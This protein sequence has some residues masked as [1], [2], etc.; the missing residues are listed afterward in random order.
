MLILFL[1]SLAVIAYTYI[2]Y[3]LILAAVSS[4]ISIRVAKK[5]IYP[6]V[7]IIVSA[8]NEG[9]NIAARISNLLS[10]DYPRE[11]MEIIIGSDGSSDETYEIIKKFAEEHGIRYTVSFNRIGKPAMINKMAKDA[12]GEI[13]VFADAR[14]TFE[15]DALKKMVS[16]FADEDI[17]AVSGELIIEDQATGTGKGMGLYWEYEKFLR[18]R[19]G[20]LGALTG[21]TGAIYAIR[22]EFFRYLPETILLDDVFVP[23]NALMQNKKVVFEPEAKAYDVVSET[24]EKEFVRKVRT[25]AGNFQIFEMFSDALNPLKRGLLA[26]ELISHKLMRLLVP[27]FLILAFFSNI[28]VLS[29]GDFYS[30][31]FLIQALFY[32]LALLGYVLEQLKINL[33]SFFRLFYIPYEFCVLNCAAI[34]ALLLYKSGKIDTRWEK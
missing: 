33:G 26:F 1:F 23:M 29:K 14:Q 10:M 22:K 5:E 19:E 20:A 13:F 30:V 9:K 27:Y 31:V 7:S 25:L 32:G 2:G 12:Q 6:Q 3:P 34:M 24:T 11:K 18:K 28:F 16:N 21:A 15:K 17:G 8:F 4:I